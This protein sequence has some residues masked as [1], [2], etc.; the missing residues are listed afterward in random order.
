MDVKTT[1]TEVIVI[2]NGMSHCYK[3]V[4]PH[5]GKPL[6]QSDQSF[7]IEDGYLTCQYHAAVFDADTGQ[8]VSGPCEGSTLSRV[9]PE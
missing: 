4:C 7:S 6:Y 1:Q 9:E 2:D 5:L 8:C 3:N